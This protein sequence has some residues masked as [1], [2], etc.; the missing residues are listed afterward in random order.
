MF[1]SRRICKDKETK[2]LRKIRKLWG[3]KSQGRWKEVD[4]VQYPFMLLKYLFESGND[5]HFEIIQNICNS[6]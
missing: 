3:N 1:R 4:R 6:V 5:G 2:D